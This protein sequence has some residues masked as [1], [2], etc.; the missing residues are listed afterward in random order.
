M[1]AP[2]FS[3]EDV[4]TKSVPSYDA[5]IYASQSDFEMT[6]EIFDKLYTEIFTPM[7]FDFIGDNG[8]TLV[9]YSQRV[10]VDATLEEIEFYLFI[11]IE[12]SIL[13]GSQTIL[14]EELHTK[15]LLCFNIVAAGLAIA[16]AM[17][18]ATAFFMGWRIVRPIGAVTLF[19]Q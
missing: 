3:R 9:G 15:F 18:L 14:A 19:T 1:Y 11:L 5:P 13:E 6:E 12:K 4:Y 17:T 2:Y 8:V 10:P 7:P 16:M